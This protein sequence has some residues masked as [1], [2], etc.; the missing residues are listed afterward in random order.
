M[1]FI[2]HRNKNFPYSTAEHLR[3]QLSDSTDH[4]QNSG[5][6]AS[7]VSLQI[8]V[9]FKRKLA[10]DII[11][12]TWLPESRV[13]RQVHRGGEA[14]QRRTVIMAGQSSLSHRSPCPCH[15]HQVLTLTYLFN[16]NNNNNLN[17]EFAPPP[18]SYC[19]FF[20]SSSASLPFSSLDTTAARISFSVN[21]WFLGLCWS[22]VRAWEW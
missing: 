17:S 7:N 2:N 4:T 5:M 20:W 15:R 16:N 11:Y 19:G 12:L 6:T 10:S 9:L 14:E 21:T 8:S 3:H 22:T 18:W 1:W 13:A